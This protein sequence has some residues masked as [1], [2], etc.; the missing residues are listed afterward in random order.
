MVNWRPNEDSG[1]YAM[2]KSLQGWSGISYRKT[3]MYTTGMVKLSWVSPFPIECVT[4]TKVCDFCGE[5]GNCAG[6]S[7]EWTAERNKNPLV[8]SLIKKASGAR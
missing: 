5:I 3:I 1:I 6:V 8:S 2:V 4:N 7:I